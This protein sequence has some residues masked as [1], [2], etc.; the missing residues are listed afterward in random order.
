M[1]GRTEL[2]RDLKKMKGSGQ[3]PMIVLKF[4]FPSKMVKGYTVNPHTTQT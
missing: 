4:L 1:C 3:M 2:L